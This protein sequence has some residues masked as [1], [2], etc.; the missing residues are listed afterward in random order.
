MGLHLLLHL[1]LLHLHFQVVHLHFQVVHLHFQVVH[2][3]F[4][5]VH[6][7][8][9]VVGV[10]QAVVVL[11]TLLVMV[12]CHMDHLSRVLDTLHPEVQYFRHH[13]LLVPRTQV[14]GLQHCNQVV[15]AR[16]QA[17]FPLSLQDIAQMEVAG[18]I[19]LGHIPSLHLRTDDLQDTDHFHRAVYSARHMDLVHRIYHQCSR[20]GSLH[21]LDLQDM[22]VQDT[23]QICGLHNRQGMS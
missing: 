4:Q 3:H 2:L 21:L 8:F 16:S 13:R 5:V 6:L 19:H 22:V 10:F 15:L 9:Q 1:L 12:L 14:V 11:H 17:E 7:H 20:S 18:Q 23:V